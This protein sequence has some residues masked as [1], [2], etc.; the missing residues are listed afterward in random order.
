MSLRLVDTSFLMYPMISFMSVPENNYAA[1]S[2]QFIHII[3][4]NISAGE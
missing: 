1:E 3:G 4:W 2:N